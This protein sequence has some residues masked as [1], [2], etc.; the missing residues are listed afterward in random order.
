[1]YFKCQSFSLT[2]HCVILSYYWPGSFSTTCVGM[3]LFEHLGSGVTLA[4]V[5]VSYVLEK[6]RA[7]QDMVPAL[8]ESILPENRGAA[9]II[10]PRVQ[11]DR[12]LC[13]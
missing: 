8:P 10:K 3:A 9:N 11:L 12:L 5:A 4:V 6:S 7:D 2:K 1:M 13:A